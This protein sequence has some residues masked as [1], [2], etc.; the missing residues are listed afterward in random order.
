M[1]FSVIIPTYNRGEIL[2]YCLDSLVYQT[3]KNFEV[4]ICD[5]GS[6]DNTKSIVETYTEKLNIT[7]LYEENWG[8]P[9][10]PRNNGIKVAKGQW[11]C[12]LDSDDLWTPD[13]LQ[14]CLE[15]INESV[16]FIYHDLKIIRK[17][18]ALFRR[19]IAKNRQ[20]EKPVIIDL[21]VNGNAILNSSAV[22][23]KSILEKIGGIS[24]NQEIIACEDYHT[25]LRI[26]QIT[27]SFYYIKKC[28][29]SY[30]LHDQGIS[31]KDMSLPWKL[32]ITDYAYLLDDRQK[33][34]INNLIQ[35]TAGR[36]AFLS[37]NLQS[38][39]E[40]LYVSFRNESFAIKIKSILMIMVIFLK[41]S[42]K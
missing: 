9:A 34:K 40:S 18:N 26:A 17:P 20:L 25:W 4:I 12:F 41:R 22:V 15:N 1:F 33:N 8:G 30:R 24:E 38:A 31:R 10:R 28:L 32:T 7:Y 29:G 16:D 6:K 5:D 3:F 21:L 42:C 35:Y 27:D 39:K 14:V 36:F 37:N 13:K 11:V 23:R 19:K 2:K